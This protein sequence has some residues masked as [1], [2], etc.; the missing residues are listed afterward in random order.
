MKLGSGRLK[1]FESRGRWVVGA[2][3]LTF[4]VTAAVSV[5]LTL[6]ATHRARGGATV[7]EVAARQ[8][9]LAERYLS[10]VLLLRAGGKADPALT[11]SV[12]SE[13]AHALLEGGSAPAMNGDDDE[14]HVPAASGVHLRAQLEQE[15]RLIGDMTAN[16]EAVIA[17]VAGVNGLPAAGGER[18][19]TSDPVQRLRVVVGLTS[20]TALNVARSVTKSADG[21]VGSLVETQLA[22][23]VGGLIVSLLLGAALIAASRRQ[24]AHF[25]TLAQSSTDLVAVLG[26]DGCR[27]AS[28]SLA[29]KV[30]RPEEDLLG[31]GIGGFLHE[32]DRA[33]LHEVARTAAPSSFS[34]R[35]RDAA[36]EWRH[37]DVRVTDLREDRHMRGVVLN[38]RDTTE[39]VLLEQELTEKARR[40][41]F[42][43]Q[44]AEALEMADEEHA[45]C[46]VVER[47]TLEVSPPTPMELLLSDSSRANLRTVAANPLAGAP[48][49]PVRSPF[50]CVAVRRGSAVV[51]DS[52]TDLNACPHLRDR[53]GG[54]CSAVCVPVSF[55]GRSLGVLH[56]TG[57][58]GAPLGRLEVDRL[59]ALAAQSGARIGTVRA[60]EKTQL[61]ALT[62]GLTGLVNRRSA[63]EKL[64]ELI[65][66]ERLFS[67][68]L[69]DLDH[70]KQLNDTHGHEAG[71]RALRLFAQVAEAT[72]RDHDIVSRWGGEE[73]VFVMP[74]LD[75][76]QALAVADRIREA[77]ARAHPGETARFTASFGIADS[78]QGGKI[79]TLLHI[80]D[81]GL[82]AA[83]Q[84]GRDRAAIGEAEGRPRSVEGRAGGAG[85]AYKPTPIERA[86]LEEEPAP[87][88][89]EIR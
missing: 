17:R 30:G 20:A 8:R 67:V 71:D 41:G 72:L 14:A 37:L 23:A 4:L 19:G 55:M 27:Y 47:A 34:M 2:I 74:E 68:A 82:Y 80:A 15:A 10:E 76:F 69:G 39:R 42:S 48:G 9:T 46:E 73:F 26:E 65:R 81:N 31:A 60:F 79:E 66:S 58:D 56:T 86:S 29:A 6:S 61:Q 62:D 35:L 87:N 7:V 38:A 49:C 22:L 13:S 28:R 75:R 36:G 16:G 52:S 21:S 70:F 5:T 43:T 57:P 63:E 88:G 11:A 53:P 33:L 45:V 89:V 18:I 83:K 84:A 3:F 24:T 78:N 54:D 51:F 12:M 25:R 40:D 59:R 44:L 85:R 77:L 50:S 64:R 1:P 32:E